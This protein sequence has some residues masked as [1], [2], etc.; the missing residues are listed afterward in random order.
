MATMRLT[1]AGKCPR[2]IL[3]PMALLGIWGSMLGPFLLRAQEGEAGVESPF[4]IGVDAKSLALG[5]AGAAYPQDPSAFHWNP[6][7]LIVV[8]Q[9][10]ML[11]SHTLLFEDVQYQTVHYVHPTLSAGAFGLG[12]TRIGKIGRASCRERV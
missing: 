10:S 5:N 8:Q 4:R 1:T 11:F 9:K 2:V 12:V 3:W 7:A 6:A